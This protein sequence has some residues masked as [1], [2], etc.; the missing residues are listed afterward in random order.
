MGSDGG[1]YQLSDGY[2]RDNR[3]QQFPHRTEGVERAWG[4]FR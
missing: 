4:N 3:Q 2:E 1:F